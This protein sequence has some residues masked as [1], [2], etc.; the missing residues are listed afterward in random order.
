MQKLIFVLIFFIST[1]T[2]VSHTYITPVTIADVEKQQLLKDRDVVFRRDTVPSETPVA[3]VQRQL[4]AYNL[5]NIEAFL[6]PYADDVE[7]YNYPN[8]LMNKGKEAMRNNYTRFFETTPDL[9]CE[10]VGRIVQGNVVID[11]ERVRANNRYFEA[12]AI[13]HIENNKIRKVYFI[14]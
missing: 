2:A 9:H 10:L 5:R 4:N 14:R 1:A 11:K 13:Y 12:V 8:T 3:L 6:E 7:I